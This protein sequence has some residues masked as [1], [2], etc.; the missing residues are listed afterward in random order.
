MSAFITTGMT[1]GSTTVYTG[2]GN[3]TSTSS[4][5]SGPF[6]GVVG[7]YFAAGDLTVGS[8]QNMKLVEGAYE[9]GDGSK[10]IVD[11]VGNFK[12]EDKDAKVTYKSN[13]MRE[14]NKFI[15]SSDLLADFIHDMGKLGADAEQVLNTP[16]QYFI[17]WLIFK[18]A[19]ADGEETDEDLS[20]ITSDAV[21]CV[22]QPKTVFKCKH[23]GK[24]ISSVRFT[25]GIMFCNGSHADAYFE[26]VSIKR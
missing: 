13:N 9:L 7:S 6:S 11:D 3:T 19:E 2:I 16:V 10:L 17:R 26:K 20:L 25:N 4:Y 23:C 21:K 18:A 12:I 22:E 8:I 1:T 24:F 5:I 14:F 15:N